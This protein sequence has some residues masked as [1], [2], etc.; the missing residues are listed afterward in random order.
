MTSILLASIVASVL[1]AVLAGLLLVAERYLVD[2][3]PCRIDVTGGKRTLDVIGGRTLLLTSLECF[4][5]LGP[6]FLATARCHVGHAQMV[7]HRGHVRQAGTGLLQESDSLLHVARL[8]VDPAK[9]IEAR[10][11]RAT[12]LDGLL[13]QRQRSRGVALGGHEEVGQ[14]IEGD[15]GDGRIV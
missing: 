12:E 15:G 13:G 14:V 9:G 10:R 7:A 6:G 5:K 1:T 4:R 11:Q 3:G 8:Q 2:Y